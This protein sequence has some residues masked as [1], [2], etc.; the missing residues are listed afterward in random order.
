MARGARSF[1]SSMQSL[2]PSHHQRSGGEAAQHGRTELEGPNGCGSRCSGHQ[3]A[4]GVDSHRTNGGNM[5]ENACVSFFPKF[6]TWP[7]V[8]DVFLFAILTWHPFDKE[9]QSSVFIMIICFLMS[10]ESG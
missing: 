4:L 1:L 5:V 2:R 10:I 6:G 8:D 9:V 7:N 3:G